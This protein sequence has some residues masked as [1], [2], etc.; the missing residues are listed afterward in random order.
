MKQ[1]FRLP[2]NLQLFADLD[3]EGEKQLPEEPKRYMQEDIDALTAKI[4]QLTNEVKRQVLKKLGLSREEIE[5]AIEHID[6]DNEKDILMAVSEFDDDL[7]VLVRVKQ[8]QQQGRR[9]VE[10]NMNNGPR[11]RPKPLDLYEVGRKTY[12]RL[13]ESGKI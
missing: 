2:L 1:R 10:P 13:K 11:M 7:P 12:H 9:G 5:Y 6:A 8:L 4:T 3:P